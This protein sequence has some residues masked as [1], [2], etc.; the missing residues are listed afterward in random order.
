M[1]RD[2]EMLTE[3]VAAREFVLTVDGRTVPGVYWRPTQRTVERLVLLGHGGST[4]KKTEYIVDIAER[5]AERGIASMAIDGPGH[6]DRA[7]ARSGEGM[8]AFE[9]LWE[10]GGGT[11]AILD[12]WRAALDFVEQHEGVR[13]TGWWG[14]SMG[15][16]MGLP[17]AATDDR[18]RLAVLGLMGTYG[19]NGS[20]LAR[21]APDVQ[22]PVRFLVQWDD[23]LIPRDACLELFGALGTAKKTLHANPGKHADVPRFEIAA[24]VDYLDRYLG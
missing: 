8:S 19:P 22:C 6:G 4:H 9:R 1:W 5:L 7:V 23:E 10:E 15:T 11:P 18:I 14:L 20:D 13:P 17:V 12:D 3:D 24:S 2:Q 16:M 21:F